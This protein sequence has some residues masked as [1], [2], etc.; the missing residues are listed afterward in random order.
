M[1]AGDD[2]ELTVT[3]RNTGSRPG[4]EV[5]QAYLAGP[6]GDPARP[7]RVLAAFGSAVAE[8]GASVQV[9]LRVPARAFARWDEQAGDWAWPA[10]QF[11]VQVGRSARD[12]PLSA[13]VQ[14][15]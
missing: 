2:L 5:V 11:E 8:P 6:P 4:R 1:A 15:G 9:P 13:R 10:G 3:V 12:L 7:V 14:S